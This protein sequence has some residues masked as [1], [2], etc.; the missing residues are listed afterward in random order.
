[1]EM[2]C[3]C[4]DTDCKYSLNIC[5]KGDRQVVLTI[6]TGDSSEEE[7]TINKEKL[8]DLLR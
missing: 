3:E 2:Q 7:I 1:M 4:G 6:R 8:R 5:N